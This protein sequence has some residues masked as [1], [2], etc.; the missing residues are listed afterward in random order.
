MSRYDEI[1]EQKK[2]LLSGKRVLRT[3]IY[4]TIK[5][6]DSDIYIQARQ[7]DRLDMLAYEYYGDVTKWWIIA[8]AN[9]IKGSLYLPQ[10]TQIRIPMDLSTIISDYKKL[11]IDA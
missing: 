4:P 2:D 3:V 10:D 5:E 9:K 6:S 1:N 8:H 7:T 11:N